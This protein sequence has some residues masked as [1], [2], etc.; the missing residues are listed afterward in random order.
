MGCVLVGLSGGLALSIQT[1]SSDTAPW[2]FRVK[3]AVHFV[4]IL[5]YRWKILSY[6]FFLTQMERFPNMSK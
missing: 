4:F 3:T 2:E 5:L 1:H 6:L